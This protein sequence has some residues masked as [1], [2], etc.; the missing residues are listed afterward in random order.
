MS[1]WIEDSS[2]VYV[3]ETGLTM[4]E[5]D[6]DGI[7]TID[8]LDEDGYEIEIPIRDLFDN[9]F[10]KIPTLDANG[11]ISADQIPSI[12]IG[13]T[14]FVNSETEMLA[15]STADKGDLAIRQDIQG[16]ATYRLVGNDYSVL[17]HWTELRAKYI[18]W[19]EILNKPTTFPVGD[20]NHDGR[21]PKIG[22][23]GKISA[24]V[25][26]FV[27]FFGDRYVRD[28]ESEMLGLLAAPGDVCIRRDENK[29]YICMGL[30]SLL[31][32]W[33][34][35]PSPI[36]KID[37]IIMDGTVYVG[38]VEITPEAIRAAHEIHEH[39][40]IKAESGE[41]IRV[42]RDEI[43][44]IP[45]LFWIDPLNGDTPTPFA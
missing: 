7:L 26:P 37:S 32:S 1:S 41:E 25:I 3:N 28:S 18:Q 40:Y 5:G 8:E 16:G 31:S 34:Y 35:V 24:G 13:D 36:A 19:S 14:F 17:S 45:V 44:G 42:I 4:S 27:N 9:P 11:K 23:N 2:G 30:P 33:V 6:G 39:D 12:V 43:D 29:L 10:V 15:L 22:A 38:H 21:Y 20:H